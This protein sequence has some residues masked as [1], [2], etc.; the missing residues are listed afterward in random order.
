MHGSTALQCA[1]GTRTSGSPWHLFSADAAGSSTAL[2][3][4]DTEHREIDADRS[5]RP[6]RAIDPFRENERLA[7]VA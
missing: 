5:V 7:A 2:E 6:I 4:V 3:G 1:R